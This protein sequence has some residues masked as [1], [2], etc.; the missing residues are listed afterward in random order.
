MTVPKSISAY[1]AKISGRG[2][3]GKARMAAMTVAERRELALRAVKAKAEKRKEREAAASRKNGAL[4]GRPA[5]GQKIGRCETC[6]VVIQEM[7]P[8]FQWAD[9]IITCLKHPPEHL[10]KTALRN[11]PE[12]KLK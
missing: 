5:L 9:G 11:G 12:G 7:S 8:Y 1:M 10:A 6:G 4:G 2:K 3:G